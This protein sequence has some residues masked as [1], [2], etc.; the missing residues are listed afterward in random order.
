MNNVKQQWDKCLEFIKANLPTEQF[1]VWFDP[2][3]ALSFDD[4]K[5]IL[6]VPSQFFVE[7]IEEQ[8]LFLLQK[9]IERN[10]GLGVKLTYKFNVA[11]NEQVQMADSGESSRLKSGPK[12]SL[13]T[14]SNPFDHEEYDDVDPQLNLRYTF[15]N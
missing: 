6:K 12:L 15:E 2:I 4:N 5:L 8:Y 13:R 11:K 10:F 7:R 1:A 9:A 14:L 3:V